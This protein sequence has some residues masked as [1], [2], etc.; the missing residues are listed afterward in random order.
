MKKILFLMLM[1]LTLGISVFAQSMLTVA[2]GTTT[3]QYVPVYGYY[4]DDFLRCQTIYPSSMLT[5]TTDI[6]GESILGVTYY[7][8]SPA[9]DSW[10]S[11]NFVVKVKEVTDTALT[12]FVDMTT[13]T[14]VYTGPLDGTQ[15][16]M[17]IDFTAPYTYQVAIC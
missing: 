16:T 3:N 11:A 10:G 2:D 9:D 6:T 13:A 4:A 12:A 8:S 17:E 15:S 5:G 7:L 14:T 1:F